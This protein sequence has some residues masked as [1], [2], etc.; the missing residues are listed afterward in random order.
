MVRLLGYFRNTI[1]GRK[2][3][4]KMKTIVLQKDSFVN[5]LSVENHFRCCSFVAPE[6]HYYTQ[7]KRDR[8]Y[9]NNADRNFSLRIDWQ[10]SFLV[11]SDGLSPTFLY[12]SLVYV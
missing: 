6:N 10:S 1:K 7:Q 2:K 3:R 9:A 8:T 4:E 5:I 12:F 11:D